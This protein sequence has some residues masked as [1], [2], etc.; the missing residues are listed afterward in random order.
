MADQ[1]IK[2]LKKEVNNLHLRLNKAY[3]EDFQYKRDIN[4]A[5]KEINEKVTPIVQLFQNANTVSRFIIIVAKFIVT[6]SG[7]ITILYGA[8][9]IFR[10]SSLF[11]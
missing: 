5:L 6:T 3:E 2:D 10:D 11:K 4:E 8:Y 9:R 1:E 7:G